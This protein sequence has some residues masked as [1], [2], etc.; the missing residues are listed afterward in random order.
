MKRGHGKSL[1]QLTCMKRQM[2]L[3]V[4]WISSS[5]K[6]S[7]TVC[8]NTCH[9]SLDIINLGSLI[10]IQHSPLQYNAED[11]SAPPVAALKQPDFFFF[12]CV[13]RSP[14]MPLRNAGLVLAAHDYAAG[15]DHTFPFTVGADLRKLKASVTPFEKQSA[16]TTQSVEAS[17]LCRNP[18][19]RAMEQHW[20]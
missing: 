4:S 2:D 13:Q 16:R 5:M 1:D 18:P 14:G 17:P 20:C 10:E 7:R 3:M 19:P 15:K 9:L 6:T 11:Y 12:F 8:L